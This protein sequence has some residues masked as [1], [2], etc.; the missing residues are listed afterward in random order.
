MCCSTRFFHALARKKKLRYQTLILADQVTTSG[1]V[2]TANCHCDSRSTHCC[3]LTLTLSEHATQLLF[4]FRC[5]S[6]AEKATTTNSNRAHPVGCN[7]RR[8]KGADL[9]SS[10]RQRCTMSTASLRGPCRLTDLNSKRDR[11]SSRA[12]SAS[13]SLSDEP[14]PDEG[15]VR[16]AWT[17]HVSTKTKARSEQNQARPS[18]AHYPALRR[19]NKVPRPAPARRPACTRG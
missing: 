8:I 19:K 10:V 1:T 17:A 13:G 3:P 7:S 12:I 15:A 16:D 14:W 11:Q 18:R 4:R 9:C 6:S 2:S 5:C